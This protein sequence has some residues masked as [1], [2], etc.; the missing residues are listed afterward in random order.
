MAFELEA[1]LALQSNSDVFREPNCHV[2]TPE[3]GRDD[4]GPLAARSVCKWT[5]SESNGTLR[6]QRDHYIFFFFRRRKIRFR[7]LKG[8]YL[9]TT[10]IVRP[11]FCSHRVGGIAPRVPRSLPAMIAKLEPHAKRRSVFIILVRCPSPRVCL[12]GRISRRPCSQPG[13]VWSIPVASLLLRP[14]G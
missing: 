10:T 6:E 1:A 2:M 14:R 4:S 8:E 11:F 12:P 9:T 3:R 13:S 5:D 7:K